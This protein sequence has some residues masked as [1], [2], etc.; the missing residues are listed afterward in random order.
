MKK[1]QLG[2][3]YLGI[4]F[5]IIALAVVAKVV[6]A[7]WPSYWDDRVINGQIT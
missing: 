4:L 6:I 7:V 2:T 1:H 5:V 3:S